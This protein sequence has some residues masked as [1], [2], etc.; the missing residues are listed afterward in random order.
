MMCFDQ[1]IRLGVYFRLVNFQF[2][3]VAVL[4]SGVHCSPVLLDGACYEPYRR[5]SK[6]NISS[7]NENY[8]F[9]NAVKK[10]QWSHDT[11]LYS[12]LLL[13]YLLTVIV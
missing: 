8:L 1:R 11:E 5:A 10:A 4:L 7:W 9:A 6:D 2:I 12:S 3:A 13:I